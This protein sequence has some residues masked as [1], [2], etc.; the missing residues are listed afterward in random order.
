LDHFDSGGGGF[1]DSGGGFDSS[2]GGFDSSGGGF[3]SGGGFGFDFDFSGGLFDSRPGKLRKQSSGDVTSAT[4]GLAQQQQN[5]GRL[6]EATEMA[7]D[8]DGQDIETL[9]SMRL[10]L[11]I[12]GSPATTTKEHPRSSPLART[13]SFRRTG[14]SP[15]HPLPRTP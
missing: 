1:F 3:D 8:P 10:G 9:S 11:L 15:V 14:P 12:P 4:V 5:R 2:G 7:V 6:L 13:S